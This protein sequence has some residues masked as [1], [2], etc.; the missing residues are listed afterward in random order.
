MKGKK[1]RRRQKHSEVEAKEEIQAE[2]N[3]RQM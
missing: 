3:E 1:E 2:K